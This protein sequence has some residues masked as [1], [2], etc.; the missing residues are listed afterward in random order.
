MQDF[1]LKIEGI[2]GQS[3]QKGHEKEIEL[4]SFSFGVT[5]QGSFHKNGTGAGK[6]KASISD[7]SFSKVVDKSSPLLFKAA[8][9]G[10]HIPSATITTQMQGG[11]NAP[12]VY[13][14]IVLTDVLVSSYQNS[15]S[16]GGDEI[17]ESFSLNFGKIDFTHTGQTNE[18]GNDAQVTGWF[19]PAKNE[20]G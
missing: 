6:G 20:A 19:S 14:K 3:V 17:M 9:S 5:N 16:Q 10:R 13:Y 7:L 1:F 18:G 12:V 4:E 8:A 2:E 15:G 11:D